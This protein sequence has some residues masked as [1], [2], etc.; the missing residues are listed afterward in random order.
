LGIVGFWGKTPGREWHKRGGE[1]ISEWIDFQDFLREGIAG[2][3][4]SYYHRMGKVNF[5]QGTVPL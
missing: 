3:V 4:L 5:S 2:L 1:V